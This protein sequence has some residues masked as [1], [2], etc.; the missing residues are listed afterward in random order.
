MYNEFRNILPGLLFLGGI[1]GVARLLSVY[2]DVNHLLFVIIIGFLI[3]NVA[4]VPDWAEPGV[5]TYKL[6]LEAGIVM[7][8]ARLVLGQFV[9]AGTVVLI[10]VPLFVTASLLYMECVARYFFGLSE[11]LSSLLASGMSICGVSAVIAVA[12]GIKAKENE[13]AYAVATILLFDAITLFTYPLIGVKLGLADQVYGIWAGLTM[14]STGP[15]TAAGFIYSDPAGQWAAITKL[16]RNVF[17]G[18]VAISY[19]LY[20]ARLNVDAE[21]IDNKIGY[22]WDQFPKFIVGF[23]LVML[24]ASIGF[25]SG[26][27]IES[28]KNGYNW[29]FM[30]AFAGLGLQI[31][32]NDMRATG[33]RPIITVLLGLVTIS[34]VTLGLLL[35]LF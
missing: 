4:G 16:A 35:V 23:V 32:V 7:M 3:G 31:N 33:I 9:G 30:V 24:I 5:D 15:V 17:I 2:I 26:D 1:V 10:L 20:Y 34:T 12:G 21:R 28:M 18:F 27:Q 22:V 19:S 11:K 13:I 25:L 6:W 29:A 8:G 14:F